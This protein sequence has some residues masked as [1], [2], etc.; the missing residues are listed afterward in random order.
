MFARVST[1]GGDMEKFLTHFQSD[2]GADDE[3][4][5]RQLPG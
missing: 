5:R 1:Y 3:Q 4:L 2:P